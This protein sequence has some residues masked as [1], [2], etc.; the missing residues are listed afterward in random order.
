M[1]AFSERLKDAYDVLYDMIKMAGPTANLK[2]EF[3][4]RTEGGIDA[5][6]PITEKPDGIYTDFKIH[7][8]SIDPSNP[9]ESIISILTW[10][11]L[12]PN[13]FSVIKYG[14]ENFIY[15]DIYNLFD[16]SHIDLGTIAPENRIDGAF[17][18]TDTDPVYTKA[19]YN[20]FKERF[21]KL[22]KYGDIMHFLGFHNHELDSRFNNIIDYIK[23]K[24][25]EF[26]RTRYPKIFDMN[27]EIIDLR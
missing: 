19:R 17:L 22:F 2:V 10:M 11:M 21:D 8:F 14:P 3:Y 12:E 20:E 23:Y 7:E 5:T 27:S 18:W 26:F 16:Q 15:L 25:L 1:E 13:I 4:A 24:V 6:L 9:S